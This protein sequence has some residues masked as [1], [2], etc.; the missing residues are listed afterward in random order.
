MLL[1]LSRSLHRHAAGAKRLGVA[2]SGGTDSTALLVALSELSL[3][4]EILALHVNHHL[5]GAESDEDE[6]FVSELAASLHIRF[7]HFDGSLSEDEVRRHGV[8]GAAREKRYALLDEA[9]EREQ[10]DVV[11]TAHHQR[12]QAETL[13]IR[14]LRGGSLLSLQGIRPRQGRFVRPLLD[15]PKEEIETFATDHR[16]RPRHDSSN[17]DRRFVRNRVRHDLLPMVREMNPGIEEHLAELARQARTLER[18]LHVLSAQ[19]IEDAVLRKNG[20]SRLDLHHLETLPWLLAHT[21][22]GEIAHLDPEARD[23]SALD[24]RRLCKIPADGKWRDVTRSLRARRKNGELLLERTAQNGEEHDLRAELTLDGEVELAGRRWRIERSN[25]RKNLRS[26]SH[27]LFE[28]PRGAEPRL[29]I[30]Q[31]QRGDRFHP[32][33]SEGEKKLK[34]FLI[35]RKIERSERDHLPLL[36]QGDQIVA[37]VGVEVSERF[38]VTG[39]GDVYRLSYEKREE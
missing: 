20:S 11:L 39:Q 27:Q 37:V 2:I 23:I 19:Q 22:R 3:D 35:D 10:I 1:E 16:L 38:K 13:L 25:E 15:V 8:E 32:L 5:R 4:G 17:D 28:L 30:R 29:L 33:G 14:L 26:P 12:D 21:L 36:V 6:L 7:L 18:D 31:R 34:D 9:A 24:L